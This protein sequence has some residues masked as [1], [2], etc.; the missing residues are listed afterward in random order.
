MVTLNKILNNNFR[1]NREIKI[2]SKLQDLFQATA[3][4]FAQRAIDAVN[5]KGIFN[6]ALSG[7]NTPKYLFD[8]LTNKKQILKQIPWRNIRFFLTDERYVPD[9]NPE[10]N[11]DMIHKHLFSK[12]DINTENIYKI[13]TEYTHPKDAAENYTATLRKVFD[14]NHNEFPKFDLV[15]LG[16]GEDAH[17]AS[18]MPFSDVL[19][20]PKKNQLVESL[21]VPK[22]RQYRITL[23]PAAINHASRIIFLVTGA[24]KASAVSAVLE[25][26]FEPQRY[27]AQ[28]I[29]CIDGKTI[30][31]LDHAAAEEL[32]G[33]ET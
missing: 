12:I 3:N 33:I 13:P 29:H 8:I 17:T 6:V 25:G 2:F 14:I 11:Y 10:S 9:N 1:L 20:D 24:N 32:R 21:W 15:Y 16:L 18:L 22:L 19:I 5:T 7:G 28:L 4:D 26:P 23:T 27:P 30:W 31:Y